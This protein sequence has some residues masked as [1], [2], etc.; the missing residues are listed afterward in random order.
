MNILKVPCNVV[1]TLFNL[2]IKKHIENLNLCCKYT[3]VFTLPLY[4][5]FI[6]IK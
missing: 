6:E 2:L 1:I 4:S 3:I 5:T